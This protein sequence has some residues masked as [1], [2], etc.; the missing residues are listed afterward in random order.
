MKGNITKYYDDKRIFDGLQIDVVDGEVTCILG[1]SGVGK[2]TLLRI[3]AGLEPF[4]GEIEN[5]PKTCAFVFQEPRLLPYLTVEENLRYV[6]A[7][8]ERIAESLQNAEIATHKTAR[9]STLS[10]GEKQ[11]VAFARAFAALRRA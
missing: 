11:R 3:L 2:T 7:K 10:G 5:A 8:E 1:A 9:A 6:G 4:D